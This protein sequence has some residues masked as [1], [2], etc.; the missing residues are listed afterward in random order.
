MSIL[1][2]EARLWFSPPS[3]CVACPVSC[4]RWEDARRSQC[5]EESQRAAVPFLSPCWLKGQAKT[6]AE[7]EPEDTPVLRSCL[8]HRYFGLFAGLQ[9]PDCRLICLPGHASSPLFS[10][11]CNFSKMIFYYLLFLDKYWRFTL[12]YFTLFWI[13]IVREMKCQKGIFECV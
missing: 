8:S 1:T 10:L 4:E 3:A 7:K 11:W 5:P 2:S 9:C 13:P 6:V 12:L